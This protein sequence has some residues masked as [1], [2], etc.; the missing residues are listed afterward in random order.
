MNRYS[1]FHSLTQTRIKLAPL[2]RVELPAA[3]GDESLEVLD[4]L[5]F[6][7]TGLVVLVAV[8]DVEAGAVVL[9][10]NG[11][12][13]HHLAA[14]G[15]DDAGQYRR[16]VTHQA[17]GLEGQRAGA[18]VVVAHHRHLHLVDEDRLHAVLAGAHARSRELD[19]VGRLDQALLLQLAVGVL[20]E[21]LHRGR[22]D[23]VAGARHVRLLQGGLRIESLAVW[24]A[25][26]VGYVVGSVGHDASEASRQK[27]PRLLGALGGA[28]PRGSNPPAHHRLPPGWF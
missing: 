8:P 4:L 27:R 21:L 19:D 24:R 10:Q 13:T 2:A 22:W 23:Q 18:L 25:R 11:A 9:F 5:L 17:H 7:V 14:A 6:R 1:S 3:V 12:E 28:Y 15:Q 26:I 16:L 20:D